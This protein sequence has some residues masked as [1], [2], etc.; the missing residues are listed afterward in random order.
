MLSCP[1]RLLTFDH[2]LV[3]VCRAQAM[4]MR[5]RA[6]WLQQLGLFPR[7]WGQD[8][9]GVFRQTYSGQITIVPP[10]RFLDTTGT[11]A[12]LTPSAEEMAFYILTGQRSCWKHL[13]H[14]AHVMEMEVELLRCSA[15]AAR[16][17]SRGGVTTCA[18]PIS[19]SP[20]DLSST[21][22]GRSATWDRRSL[23]GFESLDSD[24]DSIGVCGGDGRGG[25]F[26][27]GDDDLVNREFQFHAHTTQGSPQ[28]PATSETGEGEPV[29]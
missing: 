27:E 1:S 16:A 12:I 14:I 6:D 11:K 3:A 7:F 8:L 25:D 29:Q 19:P 24:D 15:L 17:P 5:Y 13:N 9:S 22:I 2:V 20:S 23:G 10:F 4:D 28:G 21:V 18:L 26:R